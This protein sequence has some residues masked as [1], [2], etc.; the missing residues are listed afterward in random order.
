MTGDV[1]QSFL[2][3]LGFDVD[4]S[5]LSKFNNAIAGAAA[6]VTGLYA[7]TTAAATGIFFGISKISEGFEE[8]GYQYRLI[9]PAINK[10]VALRREMMHAYSAAGV[11]LQQVVVSAVRLNFS[12]AKTKF[13]LEA[14]YK[15]VGARFFGFL[16]KQSDAFRTKLYANLPK[17]QATLEKLVASVFHLFQA[18]TDLGLRLWSILTRVYDF[19]VKLDAAT[20]GWSTIILGVVAAWKLLNLSFLA[21]PLGAV[22]SGLLAIL[23]LYDDFET[24]QEGGQS[25]FNWTKAI[26]YIYAVRDALFA[27]WKAFDGITDAVASLIVAFAQLFQGDFSAAFRSWA[28]YADT[29][30]NSLE[31][32]FGKY[33]GLIGNAA[34]N[35]LGVG[36]LV[37]PTLGSNIQNSTAST[38]NR[39][40]QK[41]NIYLQGT[42]DTQANANAIAS[43]QS[44]VSK[45]TI[46]DLGPKT[47]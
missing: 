36:A 31:G 28:S 16:T 19:F 35:T 39:V 3:G 37:S 43:Q 34:A 45:A 41:T 47:K 32:I 42:A 8:I 11:N 17:I 23:A 9:I 44:N 26:P 30:K 38:N 22:L 24:F 15:S 13:A 25:F 10:T 12:L 40:D 2:V 18:A 5:S 29:L 33:G 14:I 20:N 46:R 21:T 27:I 6:K 1:I 7:A 4:D